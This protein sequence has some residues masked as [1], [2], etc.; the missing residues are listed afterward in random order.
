M[1][2]KSRILL[3]D[4]TPVNIKLL[5]DLLR[6]DYILSVA[7]NGADALELAAKDRP[8]LVLLDIMMPDMDGYEVCTR[9]KSDE[10]TADVPVIFVTAM[11]DVEDETKG[12]E[13]GAVDFIAKPIS[14]AIVR[15]RVRSAVALRRKTRELKSLSAKLS[16]YLSPQL[17]DSIFKGTRDA[18]I[19]SRR[20]KLTVFFSDIVGFTDTTER[21]EAEEMSALLNSYLDRMSGIV[22]KHG[23]TIDK[24]MGD[25]I[26][27]FFGDPDSKGETQDALSCV[28]MAMEMR[29][30]MK[31]FRREWFDRGVET[32]F[33]VRAGINSGYCTVGNFGSAERMEYTIIGGQVNIA[34]RLESNAEPD[35]ILISHETWSLVR[36]KIYCIKK[37]PLAL[38]GIPYPVQT[39]QVVDLIENVSGGDYAHPVEELAEQALTI[40][41]ATTVRE[42]RTQLSGEASTCLIIMGGESEIA[43]IVTREMIF[44]AMD[45]GN[46]LAVLDGPVSA[47][48]NHAPLVVDPGVSVARASQLAADRSGVLAY[49][50]LILV[51]ESGIRGVVP[52]P[53]LMGRLAKLCLGETCN[54]NKVIN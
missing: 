12:F 39:Y 16:R 10:S 33:R 37:Q 21:L 41:G 49:S 52:L 27:A 6:E 44:Q 40:E 28:L 42:A 14:P 19:G 32:P 47:V 53:V 35:Q 46:P 45:S 2:E 30:A 15:S 1:G 4:D 23:G 18:L 25:A 13:L 43:G 34:S 9:L 20:K 51:N 24:F 22:I 26:M 3:V 54:D 17:Y 5:A 29:E 38:K 36:D 11:N 8:D 7:T 50:P 31:E 48:M